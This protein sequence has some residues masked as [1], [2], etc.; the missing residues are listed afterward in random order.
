MASESSGEEMTKIKNFRV[1]LR[2]REIA[3]WLK[4]ERG[5]ETTP[6]LEL[7]IAEA[8]KEAKQWVAPG[9][10]YTTLTRKT[11]EKTT[12]IPL[13]PE[14]V[15]LSVVVVSIGTGLQTQRKTAESGSQ[16]DM[17][18]AALEQEAL[19]QSLQFTVRLIGEQAEEED[20]EMSS[21]VSVQEAP[22]ASSLAT[23]LGVARIGIQFDPSAPEPPPYVRVSYWF[24]TPAGQGPSRRAEPA[25]RAEKVAA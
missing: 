2:P 21:P 14:A 6:E 17:I 5:V 3:R 25:G 19:S 23:L 18:L 8:V 16:R 22:V 4:K 20:C 1:N 13:P 11:A 10:V 15:A 9:A 7:T 24:W 12:T